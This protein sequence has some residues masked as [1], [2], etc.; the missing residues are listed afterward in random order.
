MMDNQA[1]AMTRILLLGGTT[2]ASLL[3]RALAEAGLD[4]VFS[5]AGR[6]AD[7]VAQPLPQRIGG[8]G[9]VEGLRAY[10]MQEKI[11]HVVDATHP[12]AAQMSSHAVEATGSD[13]PLIALQR[14]PWQATPQDRWTT[15]A[16]MAA[17][18]DALPDAATR[19]FLAIGRQ[20]VDAFARAPQHH[21]LLRLVDQ[22]VTAVALPNAEIIISRGPFRVE[23]DLELMRQYGVQTIVAKNSGGVGARA[24]IDAARVLGL[25]VIMID[26]PALP[27]RAC[28]E[29][30]AEVMDWLGHPTLRGV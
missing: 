19:V 2:E 28:C 8:F 15:V 10:L 30:V 20:H 26:R 16:D 6:T 27:V 29:T 14:L 23:D 12:F 24:K 5:Y 17:A 18:V 3:A 7:P 1:S 13:I 4:A 25:P 21:Y 9:G 11:S 22:P